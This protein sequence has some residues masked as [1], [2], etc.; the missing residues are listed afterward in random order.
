MFFNLIMSTNW[1]WIIFLVTFPIDDRSLIWGWLQWNFWCQPGLSR[2]LPSRIPSRYHWVRRFLPCGLVLHRQ[3][4]LWIGV[5]GCHRMLF[6]VCVDDSAGWPWKL[7][8]GLCIFWIQNIF[9]I[10]DRISLRRES[11][12]ILLPLF[13]SELFFW[14]RCYIGSNSGYA[15]YSSCLFVLL[16]Q[17]HDMIGYRTSVSSDKAQ[18]HYCVFN[19]F[20]AVYFWS[21]DIY[22]ETLFRTPIFKE[23]FVF[24]GLNIRILFSYWSLRAE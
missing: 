6:V 1:K 23:N 22:R 4:S 12:M 11:E 8:R 3:S 18:L 16:H 24:L 7:G 21:L 15:C 13:I 9:H 17:L 2:W 20:R 10:A 5:I 14:T 19:I